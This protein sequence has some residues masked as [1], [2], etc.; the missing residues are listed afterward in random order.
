VS[1][2]KKMGGGPGSA[3]GVEAVN[4]E[5]AGEGKEGKGQFQK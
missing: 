2:K 3:G 4:K 1:G 5:E